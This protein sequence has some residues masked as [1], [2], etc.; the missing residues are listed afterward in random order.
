M[1]LVRNL[2]PILTKNRM[3]SFY[4][5]APA[6]V[7]FAAFL[8]VC[9]TSYRY[10][11]LVVLFAHV[12]NFTLLASLDAG[13]FAKKLG[14]LP[15]YFLLDLFVMWLMLRLHEDL[16]QPILLTMA[17][18]SAVFVIVHGL[19]MYAVYVKS[20]N[21]NLFYSQYEN[22]IF[23]LNII[24]AS[25]FGKSAIRGFRN[26]IIY[27]R[28]YFNLSRSSGSGILETMATDQVHKER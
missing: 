23:I 21:D 19:C 9:Y 27:T 20:Y 6:I 24:Q 11:A 22:I 4:Y 14:G 16:K 5:I 28:N 12:L 3:N 15:F 17:K 7:A 2:I 13:I 25:L 1:V 8:S 18:I 10:A 26:G